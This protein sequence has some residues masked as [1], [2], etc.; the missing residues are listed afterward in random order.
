MLCWLEDGTEPY[1][2]LSSAPLL[3]LAIVWDLYVLNLRFILVAKAK[4]WYP[5]Q[6][7]A[8]HTC[9]QIIMLLE[10]LFWPPTGKMVGFPHAGKGLFTW[11][12]KDGFDS[13]ARSSPHLCLVFSRYRVG[14]FS[15]KIIL[16]QSILIFNNIL[17]NAANRKQDI[18][19]K[20]HK[21]F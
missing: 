1:S 21:K 2:L 20:L 11:H 4:L 15:S 6:Q 8:Q 18:C 5:W 7:L 17:M 14:K 3:P 16:Y 19:S 9:T 12:W 10:W 13:L